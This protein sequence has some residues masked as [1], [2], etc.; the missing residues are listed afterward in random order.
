[1]PRCDRALTA[2]AVCVGSYAAPGFYCRNASFVCVELITNCQ[3]TG[4]IY[5]QTNR[6][7]VQ[8]ALN[9]HGGDIDPQLVLNNTCSAMKIRFMN[10]CWLCLMSPPMHPYWTRLK[11]LFF[12]WMPPPV[13]A[14][15]AWHIFMP[16][17]LPSTG[18]FNLC[19]C[20]HRRL[21]WDNPPHSQLSRR[22]PTCRGVFCLPIQVLK[23]TGTLP[24]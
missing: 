23:S 3:R 10:K 9:I 4:C 16:V 8:W 17:F 1:M 5:I 7:L 15:F 2:A 20:H 24:V 12:R 13:C 19:L 11:F 14:C 6:R 22:R 21:H 18:L